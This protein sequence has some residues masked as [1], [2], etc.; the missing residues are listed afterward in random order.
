MQ[1]VR[2]A[3]EILSLEEYSTK[4][5]PGGDLRDSMIKIPFTKAHGS[6]NDFLLTVATEAPQ[7]AG[8]HCS[9]NQRT[10]CRLGADGCCW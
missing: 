6:R 8:G 9:G 4:A 1:R 10:Q 5:P 2:R 3:T 7:H